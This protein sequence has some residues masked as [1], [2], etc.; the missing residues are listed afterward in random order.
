MRRWRRTHNRRRCA[1][2]GPTRGRHCTGHCHTH[3]DVRGPVCASC[4]T[5]EGGGHR[6]I[7]RPGA[8]RHLLL[9][10]SHRAVH[11]RPRQAGVP[12]TAAPTAWA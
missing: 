12:R 11:T 6:F 5:Y 2:C 9:S 7:H 4:N 8:L 1:D 10:P 3:G